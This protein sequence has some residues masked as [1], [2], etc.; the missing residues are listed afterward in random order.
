MSESGFPIKPVY[1]ESDLPDQLASR[2]GAPGEYPYTRGVYGTMYTSRPWTMRQYAG[3]G[4]AAESNARYHHLLAA[5]TT[6]LSVADAMRQSM[7]LGLPKLR[8]R[9][10]KS[11]VLKPFTAAESRQAFGPD[12]EWDALEAEMARLPIKIEE[13]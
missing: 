7:K 10:G 5:G 11:E 1:D 3:F 13:E 6:G 2:L 9:L 8:E 4:T 12:P